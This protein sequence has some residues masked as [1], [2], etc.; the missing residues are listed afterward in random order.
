MAAHWNIVMLLT[1]FYKINSELCNI[2]IKY[3]YIHEHSGFTD[4]F[5]LKVVCS[6]ICYV[7]LPLPTREHWLLDFVQ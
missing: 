2:V 6:P 7:P 4:N 3:Y 5:H 1:V